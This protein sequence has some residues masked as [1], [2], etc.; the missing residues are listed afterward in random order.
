M[1]TDIEKE[2]A[3][4]VRSET[5]DVLDAILARCS[6]QPQEN[7][8]VPI[9][10]VKKRGGK[11]VKAMYA[12]AAMLLLFVGGYFGIGQYREAYAAEYSVT[13]DADASVRLEVSK[14]GRVVSAEG[15]DAKGKATV[16][17]AQ[18]GEKLKGQ[19]LDTAIPAIVAAMARDGAVSDQGAVLVTVD[20][21]DEDEN[22]QVKA[23]V[24]EKVG[25][26]LT[27]NGVAAAVLSQ[28]LTQN[29]ELTALAAKYGISEG[30]AALVE[31]TA[32]NEPGLE[33][34]ELAKLEIGALAVLTQNEGAKASVSVTGDAAN[35]YVTADAAAKSACA[36]AGVTLG[37][38][39]SADV[40]ADVAD[41][42][43]VYNVQLTL[44]AGSASCEIDARTG[45]I[46]RW[47]EDAAAAVQQTQSGTAGSG[48]AQTQTGTAAAADPTAGTVS[49]SAASAG[50]A[51]ATPSPS[52][53]LHASVK[54][55]ID[56]GTGQSVLGKV[57]GDIQNALGK[58]HSDLES[59]LTGEG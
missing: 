38:A 58:L 8:V 21:P 31:K 24:T 55:D 32:E 25:S 46:L 59:S 36:K 12:A 17:A 45:T 10:A 29:S 18:N 40:A 11:W 47:I 35:A 51:T 52:G 1:R 34:S 30:R 3:D 9:A 28:I 33:E 2:L 26:A 5:P 41:G 27:S 57:H 44:P 6:A 43:L 16:D 20:G 50:T 48:T 14:T 53:D 42:K 13:L 54:V 7:E 19:K 37:S 15:L 22:A 39:A 4:E 23:A 49:G 56:L